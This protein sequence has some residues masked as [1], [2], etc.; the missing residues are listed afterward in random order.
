MR[1]RRHG[2][3]RILPLQGGGC[4]IEQ[5]VQIAVDLIDAGI[6]DASR[7]IERRPIDQGR[8]RRMDIAVALHLGECSVLGFNIFEIAK[9]L[10]TP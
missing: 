9:L 8:Q 5:L 10:Q 4:R 2:R 1:R 7:P 3:Q 6:D